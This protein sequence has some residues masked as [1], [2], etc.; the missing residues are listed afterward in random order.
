VTPTD[1]ERDAQRV[2]AFGMLPKKKSKVQSEILVHGDVVDYLLSTYPHARFYSSMDG[3]N[4]T[5]QRARNTKMRLRWGSISYDD[6]GKMIDDGL[7][8]PD[9]MVFVPSG[10]YSMLVLELKAQN[11]TP[12]PGQESW[13]DY[14]TKVM[15]AQ[16]YFAYGYE[17]AVQKIKTYMRTA[18]L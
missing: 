15:G 10:R 1:A 5:T 13:L 6:K 12:G 7:G 9:L 11:G 8:F 4:M 16:A 14:F 18:R 17:D 2:R 3:I